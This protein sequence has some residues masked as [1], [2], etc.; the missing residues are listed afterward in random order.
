MIAT[1]L[2][3]TEIQVVVI[4][5]QTGAVPSPGGA[6]LM[7]EVAMYFIYGCLV[8]LV[9]GALHHI[10]VWCSCS[11]V[12]SSIYPIII[13]VLVALKRSTVDNGGL[14]QV[15]QTHRHDADAVEE[16]PGGHYFLPSF[17]G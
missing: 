17:H 13:I 11:H 9:V 2:A 10:D 15:H 14:S 8:P 7:F 5:Y 4:V 3:T 16:G 6:G 1:G 12:T